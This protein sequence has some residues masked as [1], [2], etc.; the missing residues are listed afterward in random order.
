M[1]F[2]LCGQSA[3]NMSKYAPRTEMDVGSG[4]GTAGFGVSGKLP[5]LEPVGI[6]ATGELLTSHSG[7]VAVSDH[8]SISPTASA[9]CGVSWLPT[10][11]Q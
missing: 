2:R 4:T 10:S 7:G 11:F 8:P 5:L 9:N 1:S 3:A 6:G